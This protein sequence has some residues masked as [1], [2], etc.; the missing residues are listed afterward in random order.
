MI[1]ETVESEGLAHYSYVLGD[2]DAGECLVIDPRRDVDRYLE[3]ARQNAVRITRI[4]ETH[5]H[6]DFISGSLE[7]ADRT[8]APVGVGA[9]AEVTFDHQPLEDGE[10]L[11]LG[12]LTLE[13]IHTPGHTP[14]HVCYLVRGGTRS[15]APWGI[16]TG[17]T[18]FA[19]EVGR[20]DL[21]GE[22][23]EQALARELFDSLHDRLLPLDPG[24]TV[25]PAH[26]EGSPCGARI[27]E[28]ATTTIGYE[29]AHN[30][31]LQISARD[32][33]AHEILESL[34]P[35]PSYYPRMKAINARGPEVVG[36]LPHPPA[37]TGKAFQERRAHEDALV[38]DTREI[39]A[40]GGAHIPD[41]L[42]IGLREAFPVW[43]GR[44]LPPDRSLLLVLSDGSDLP[45]VR[46][47]LL[48]IGLMNVV[49]YLRR[50]IRGWTEAGLPFERVP[51]M[52]V[53][54][55]WHRIE[56]EDALQ[57]LDVRSPEEWETGHVP[58]ASHRYV[59]DLID[60]P[61][62]LSRDEPVAVYCGSGYRASL[63]ASLLKREGFERVYN[64]PGSM[65]AWTS[66]GYPL[67]GQAD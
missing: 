61:P 52:S 11:S 17:D 30:P 31:A 4:L 12:S 13:V 53:H 42:S 6:A 18:L 56:S 65:D 7:L 1:F 46:R 63:A 16:F 41:S 37:L 19:G 23:S 58:S 55:L 14:E 2:E 60:Q 8:Q 40:F 36:A 21:L 47:H 35:A 51:Q 32:D 10:R 64:V 33:F 48:R 38:V 45:T 59:P 67:Q 44:A 3:I 34:S 5:V 54:D 57:V 28:R 20:P 50:G 27:G 39:E 22:G 9:S 25:Y 29:R 43:A 66:A 26:G 24:M 62:S 15:D 49:G